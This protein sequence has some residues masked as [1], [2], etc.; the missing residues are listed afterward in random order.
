MSLNIFRVEAR[1]VFTW[2]SGHLIFEIRLVAYLAVLS[3]S[4]LLIFSKPNTSEDEEVF[5]AAK[6]SFFQFRPH[7][8]EVNKVRCLVV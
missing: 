5:L 7:M 4:A 2:F 3:L 1:T 6:R 8:S